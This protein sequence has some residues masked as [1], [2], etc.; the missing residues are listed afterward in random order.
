M[1]YTGRGGTFIAWVAGH[2]HEDL[3]V[4]EDG[5]ISVSTT[6]DSCGNAS[7]VQPPHELGTI[8]E[9]TFDV[10]TIDKKSKKVHI[11]RIGGLGRDREFFYE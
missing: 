11:T 9:Q 5:I 6:N 4:E 8:T 3:I 7:G 2:V 1:D 10:Y